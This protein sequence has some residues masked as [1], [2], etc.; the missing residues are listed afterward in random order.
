MLELGNQCKRMTVL[1]II[2]PGEDKELADQIKKTA[3]VKQG[4]S[5]DASKD[6]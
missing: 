5:K 4:A 3:I 2:V 1:N 6:L